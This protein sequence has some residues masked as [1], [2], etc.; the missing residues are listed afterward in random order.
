MSKKLLFTNFFRFLSLFFT[1]FCAGDVFAQA[2]FFQTTTQTKNDLNSTQVSRYE[3]SE[4][5]DVTGI[6]TFIQ[7]ND[8][9]QQVADQVLELQVPGDAT[10]YSYHARYVW[11][12]STDDITWYGDLMDSLGYASFQ[13]KDGEVFGY[14][15]LEERDFFIRPLGDDVYILVELEEEDAAVCGYNAPDSPTE[16][17]PE[18]TTQIASDRE[19]NCDVKVLVLYTNN[20]AEDIDNVSTFI[21][22]LIAQ[23]NQALR[24]SAVTPSELTF[25]L[26]GK[27]LL[28]D[29]NE[30][31]DISE[32]LTALRTNSTALSLRN[33][34]FADCVILL[35][36]GDYSAGDG[37]VFGLAP[38]CEPAENLAFAIVEA[39]AAAS[40]MSF[41][42]E[43]GHLFGCRHS[44]GNNNGGCEPD[45][46]RPHEFDLTWRRNLNTIMEAGVKKKK[47]I[48]H[49][50]NPDVQYHG[51]A[52]GLYSTPSGIAE[53]N[54]ARQLRE[55]ACIVGEY[56]SSNDLRAIIY[57]DDHRCISALG[58]PVPLVAQASGG[59]P[60]P[61]TYLWQ[62]SSD[63]INYD[64]TPLSVTDNASIPMPTTLEAG[65]VVFIKL[66]VTSGTGQM[67]VTYWDIRVL[68]LES[69]DCDGERPALLVSPDVVVNPIISINP[70]P[71]HSRTSILTPDLWLQDEFSIELVS[72][73]GNFYGLHTFTLNPEGRSGVELD[74]H[75]LPNGAYLVRIKSR[76]L[77]ATRKL[78]IVH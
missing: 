37:P 28:S 75:L 31:D 76:G 60:G 70:N 32:D 55:Q 72:V 33:S 61:Y 24:N 26:A 49:F 30:G 4:F 50:S 64:P 7:I 42:H 52:T 71:A 73:L 46:Q 66:V 18:E 10:I 36:D 13:L 58:I 5:S 20:A 15:A 40:R 35:T 8:F 12:P 47:R 48:P 69:S 19:E 25:K 39:D 62:I 6:I 9:A 51:K 29:F 68:P 38:S 44:V 63:G 21:S 77:Y 3:K 59:G 45:F 16:A 2:D 74:T 1:L 54:N 41:T 67:Y 27:A 53:R 65:D 17:I 57:G 56:Q 14:F 78:V 22:G 43:L 11:S 34:L 23:S